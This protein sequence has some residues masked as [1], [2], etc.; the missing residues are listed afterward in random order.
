MDVFLV[1][2]VCAIAAA[3]IAGNVRLLLHYQQPEDAE[4]RSSIGIKTVVVL[5]MT[6]AWLLNMLLPIDVRNSRPRPGPVDM[7]AVW[8][9]GFVVLGVF[10][11][12][13]V[14][15][16]LFYSEVEGDDAVRSKRRYVLCH[17]GITLFFAVC[18][19][20]ISFPFLADASLPVVRYT[21]D[22]W[23]GAHASFR[24]DQLAP[25]LCSSKRPAF[26]DIKVGFQVYLIAV[27]CFIGWFFFVIFGG[28]GLSAIPVDLVLAYVDRPR[29][30]DEQTYRHRRRLLGEVAAALIRTAEAMREKDGSV[31]A[32]SGLFASRNKRAV[33]SDYNKFRRDVVLLEEEMERLSISKFHRG[34]NPAVSLAKLV[35]GILCGVMSLMWVIH[36]IASV[37]VS[38]I[39]PA[40][41]IP[42]LDGIFAA[43]ES[44][45]VYPLGVA[46]FAVFTLYLLACTVYGC[47][48]FGMRIFFFFSVHPM[49]ARGTPLN[50]ILFNVELVLVTSAAVVQFTQTA[51]QN[52]ARLTSAEVIFSAQVK[53]VKFFSFFFEHNI[54]IYCLLAWCIAALVFLLVKP[55]DS[56]VFR[57]D[58]KADKRLGKIL[59]AKSLDDSPLKKSRSDAAQEAQA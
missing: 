54:F 16:T 37:M 47:M 46:L 24:P 57:W 55:R 44:A 1:I 36:I 22:H 28:I 17:L 15:A 13:V 53:Y 50:S 27:L 42:V 20:G 9:G 49:R 10:L 35:F 59:G 45:G 51:F 12:A 4:W 33:R 2:F 38:H 19:I 58:A 32:K 14:P 26:L 56:S 48:K 34:E 8:Q 31:S 11:F 41:Q 5:S 3:A 29:A 6:I 30:I 7:D 40:I 18:A 25:H 21:C 43:C 52:Y 39:S 23:Q